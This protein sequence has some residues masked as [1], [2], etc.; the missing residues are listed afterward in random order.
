MVLIF[1]FWAEQGFLLA[2]KI[3]CTART[4]GVPEIILSILHSSL[5]SPNTKPGNS[6]H[7][8]PQSLFIHSA[9]GGFVVRGAWIYS[10]AWLLNC[11]TAVLG[12]PH[13]LLVSMCFRAG[14]RLLEARCK[15]ASIVSG[16]TT[17]PP[18]NGLRG[19]IPS[20][21]QTPICSLTAI[22]TGDSFHCET[23]ALLVPA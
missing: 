9:T 20:L 1:F 10:P 7:S 22:H 2:A 17:K 15:A 18:L 23:S 16:P 5:I 21:S 13:L 8:G 19:R 11:V 4:V 3:C 12:A 6:W 14:V